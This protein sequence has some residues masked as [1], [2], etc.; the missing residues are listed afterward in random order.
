MFDDVGMR[1]SAT[2]PPGLAADLGDLLAE[3]GELADLELADALEEAERCLRNA[4]AV[5]AAVVMAVQDRVD[6]MGHRLSGATQTIAAITVVSTRAASYL[7]EA[8]SA[9]CC[10]QNIWTALANGEIDATRARLIADAFIDVPDPD[11][12]VLESRALEYAA[13]HTAYQTRRQLTRLLVDY[14]PDLAVEEQERQKAKAW[15]RRYL[16]IEPREHGMADLHGYLPS[17]TAH[18][19]LNALDEVAREYADDR[20]LDQKRVD[21]LAQILAENVRLH[22][23]VDVI[24]PADT[25]AE[26]QDMGAGVEGFGAIDAE[27]GRSL[28]LS[29]DARWRG[30]ITDPYTGVLTQMSSKAYRI[31]DPM[32]RAVRARDRRCRFPGCATSAKHTDTDHVIAW[33][34]GAT[35]PQN[36]APECRRHHR[37]KTHSGWSCETNSDGSMTWTSPLGTRHTS[38]PWDYNNPEY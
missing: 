25:L 11:R 10:R 23:N 18:I 22:V 9:V 33:P 14:R 26:W 6:A 20:T 5:R 19:L 29:R 27:H 21:A 32:K 16:A 1:D 34:K 35:R 38:Y 12:R 13:S 8:S 17:G 28:A 3:L 36:L 37:V 2:A 4:Q 24:I 31:P 7:M 30:L 15:D